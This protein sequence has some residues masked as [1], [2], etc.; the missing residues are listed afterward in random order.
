MS[1]SLLQFFPPAF[2]GRNPGANIGTPEGAV[3]PMVLLLYH[4]LSEISPEVTVRL[5]TRDRLL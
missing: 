2:Q 1:S 3:R 4:R 5:T